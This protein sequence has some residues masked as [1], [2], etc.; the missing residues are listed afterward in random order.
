[1][2]DLTIDNL[3]ALERDPMT[4]ALKAAVLVRRERAAILRAKVDAYVAPVFARF[5]FVSKHDGRPIVRP[6]ELYL[7]GDE[8][9]CAEFYAACDVAHREHG[10]NMPTGYCP[11]LVA[12]H[13]V[14]KAEQALLE[15][16]GKRLGVD[17]A[18]S[19]GELRQKALTLFLD[20]PQASEVTT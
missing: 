13:D 14:I 10:H 16:Y 8:A 5:A 17:F 9:G 3:R 1:M 11:A 12:E 18:G 19:Y 15:H 6:D 4:L 7:S 20:G 2:S